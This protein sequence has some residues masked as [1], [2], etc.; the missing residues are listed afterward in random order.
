MVSKEVLKDLIKEMQ[1]LMVE[2]P[3]KADSPVDVA[4]VMEEMQ[5]D[6]AEEGDDP[7]E[8]T[9]RCAECGFPH[10]MCDCPK[11]KA[12]DGEGKM[13]EISMMDIKPL[14]KKVMMEKKEDKPGIEIMLKGSSKRR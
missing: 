1:R 3:E 12:M 2:R 10:E 14:M 6:K 9:D 8:D 11:K 5:E 13:L 4:E 7:S